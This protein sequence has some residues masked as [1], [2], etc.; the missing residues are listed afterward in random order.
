MI[1]PQILP[2]FFP[3]TPR[4]LEI[5][6]LIVKLRRKHRRPVSN[7]EI[8]K[9]SGAASHSYIGRVVRKLKARG[10]YP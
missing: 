5:R 7:R 10:V 9:A 2:P 6:K 8:A 1:K 4:Q 3:L